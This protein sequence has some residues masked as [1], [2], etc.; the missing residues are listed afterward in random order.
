[1]SRAVSNPDVQ[2]NGQCQ[3][4]LQDRAGNQIS[5]IELAPAELRWGALYHKIWSLP[6]VRTSDDVHVCVQFHAQGHF[7]SEIAQ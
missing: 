3:P 7:S 1:M 4:A 5:S 2:S 6:V